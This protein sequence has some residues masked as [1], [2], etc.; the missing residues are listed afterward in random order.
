LVQYCLMNKPVIRN[1]SIVA[2]IDHG[3]TTLTDRIL[4]M[5]NTISEREFHER[6]LDSNPIE[7]ERGITIKM[8]PVTMKYQLP[9]KVQKK[10]GVAEATFNL[11]D[12][13][14]HVDFSYEVSRSLM[15][16]EGVILLIDATQGIQ[17]QTLSHYYTAKEHGLALIPV[18]NKVDVQSADVDGV[19]LELM[20]MLEVHEDEIVKVSAKTGYGVDSLMQAIL[21]RIPEP[22]GDATSPV[23]GLVFNSFYHPNKGVVVAVRMRGGRIEAQ[24]PLMLHATKAKFSPMEVGVFDPG[25]DPQQTLSAQEVGYIATGLKDIHY[26][27]VGDT[28][29]DAHEP[30]AA[31]P[32]YKPPQLMVYMDFYPIDGGEFESLKTALEKLSLNDA[33]LQYFPTHSPALGNG[34]RVGFLGVLH[35]EIVRE[36]LNREYDIAMVTTAP[37][38]LYKVTMNDGTE[39]E[40]NNAAELPDP[41]LIK[42]IREPVARVHMYTPKDYLGAVVQL[43]EDHRGS[44]V[45]MEYVGDRNK[46]TYDLPLAEIIVTFFDELKSVSQGY[47]SL[48]YEVTGYVPVDAVKLAILINRELV[49]AFSQIVVKDKAMQVGKQLVAKLAEV[50]PRQLFPIPIQA[51]IGGTIVARDTVKAFRKDVEAKLHGGDM[52]R[53]RKLLEKQKKGKKR[54]AQFGKVEIPQEAFMEVLKKD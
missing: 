16:V 27:H 21:D 17:A 49:E 22:V 43:A 12:T 20:E 19:S 32:G 51:A 5:T 40:V 34:F 15:A 23:Q 3:K 42:E 35:A 39:R 25:M 53:N 7:Q 8:A 11:I 4:L 13:P 46:I 31:L 10:W 6:L 52:S 1:F 30:A 47:A 45:T 26:A 14:G 48:D 24:H 29:V 54:R 9:H 18:L 50:I 2:H 41:S 36:R 44:L 28:V 33:A 38:V 37:S